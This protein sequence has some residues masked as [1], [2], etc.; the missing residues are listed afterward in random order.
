MSTLSFRIGA[1]AGVGAAA[2]LAGTH[3]TDFP[4]VAVR[5]APVEPCPEDAADCS[6]ACEADIQCPDGFYCGESSHECVQDCTEE[7]GCRANQ[8]C[9]ERGHCVDDAPT[10]GSDAD[11]TFTDPDAT[12]AADSEVCDTKELVPTPLPPILVLMVDHSS[13]MLGD[14]RGPVLEAAL[15]SDTGAITQ[16]QDRYRIGLSLYSNEGAQGCPTMTEV[17]PEAGNAAALLSAYQTAPAGSGRPTGTALDKLRGWLPGMAG[18]KMVIMLLGGEPNR[19]ESTQQGDS[20]SR[21]QAE[22]AVG[23]LHLFDIDVRVISIGDGAVNPSH[24]ANMARAGQGLPTTD[25]TVNGYQVSN[26]GELRDAILD[27][28]SRLA[29]GCI[30]SL[31]QS[32]VYNEQQTGKVTLDGNPVVWDD[33]T[34][35]GGGWRMIRMG[36]NV[37]SDQFELTGSVCDLIRDGAPHLLSVTFPCQFVSPTS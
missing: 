12:D 10:T 1:L 31:D 34:E 18:P 22:S 26:Q 36:T 8:H 5:P 23:R 29:G 27:A 35:A 33:G 25:T 19:C 13:P 28:A 7:G 15:F 9:D 17:M 6:I 20:A 32:V 30:F 2:V 16:L 14:A 3:C 37:A 11:I 4:E 24:L 21:V